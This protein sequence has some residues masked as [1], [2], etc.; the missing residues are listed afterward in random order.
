MESRMHDGPDRYTRDGVI[1]EE[2]DQQFRV[3]LPDWLT[4]DQR[5][6]I[7]AAFDEFV[8]QSVARAEA[9]R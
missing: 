5:R 2:D 7:R 9:A 3:F 4:S 8:A 6:R 1:I